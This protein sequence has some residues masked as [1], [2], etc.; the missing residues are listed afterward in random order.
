MKSAVLGMKYPNP[1]PS[2]I[3]ANIQSVRKRSRNDR[4]FTG[5]I[6][7]LCIIVLK[8]SQALGPTSDAVVNSCTGALAEGPMP[9]KAD[10]LPMLTGTGVQHASALAVVAT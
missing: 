7:E 6:M 1:T 4:R 10:Y 3:A 8:Q 5:S 2:A 9:T